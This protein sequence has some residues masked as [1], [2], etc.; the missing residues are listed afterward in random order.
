MNYIPCHERTFPLY[1]AFPY[2]YHYGYYLHWLKHF[3]ERL[4]REATLAAWEATFHDYDETFL[5]QILSTGWIEG[6]ENATAEVEGRI[7]SLLGQLFA[8]PVEG[9]SR[10]QARELIA[11]APPFQQIGQ[12]FPHLD[13]EK[14]LTTYQTLHLLRD[15]LAL[16]AEALIDRHGKQGEFIFYDAMLEELAWGQRRSMSVEEFMTRRL[17]RF[18]SKPDRPDIF[19]AGLEMESVQGSEEEVVNKVI[20]C[21]WARYYRER[22]PRVGYML[23]CGLDNAAYRSF[24]DR[25]RLQRT[26]TLMEGGDFCDFRVYAVPEAPVSPMSEE[27]DRIQ[28][29]VRAFYQSW[30]DY[31][32]EE[33]IEILHPEVRFYN[34]GNDDQFL[35]RTREEFLEQAVVAPRDHQVP[36]DFEIEE[37]ESVAVHELIASV[38]V[39]WQMRFPDSV[40]RHRGHFH[41][42]RID[43]QW[44]ILS[45]TDR[46]KLSPKE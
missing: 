6:E 38:Q 33:M 7:E 22:H 19:S 21:E 10:E 23:A 45:V 34:V 46:G 15:G 3:L 31:D 27:R 2:E 12:R 32:V 24:N 29:V 30:Q 9:V 44:I 20:E 5:Q 42:G 16:L 8:V 37:I 41:L 11:S 43:D 1:L 14:N 4:G 13:V 35:V 17:A 28:T 26:T 39:R 18:S 36:L 25:I 40:G